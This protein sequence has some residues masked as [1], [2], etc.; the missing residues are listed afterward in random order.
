MAPQ[1]QH[2]YTRA[3]SLLSPPFHVLS[4]PLGTISPSCHSKLILGSH[5]QPMSKSYTY[6][7]QNLS[8][9]RLCVSI[10][11]VK[12]LLRT[13]LCCIS[14]TVLSFSQSLAKAILLQSSPLQNDAATRVCFAC[15]SDHII[16]SFTL[17]PYT[18][19]VATTHTDFHF[20]APS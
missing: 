7:Q 4:A 18:L 8:K 10:L 17:L 2:G 16:L 1:A 14:I 19:S 13:W 15:H 3:L 20:Q 5:S 9:I 11:L 6:F 12:L